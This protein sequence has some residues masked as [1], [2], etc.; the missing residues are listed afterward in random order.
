MEERL[1]ELREQRQ[2]VGT[3]ANQALAGPLPPATVEAVEHTL[4]RLE[5]ALRARAAAR[6]GPG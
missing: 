6:P 4:G 2:A 3:A 1:G 5:A